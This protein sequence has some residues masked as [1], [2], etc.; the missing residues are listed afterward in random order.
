AQS[1]L[2]E[3]AIRPLLDSLQAQHGEQRTLAIALGQLAEAIRE[4]A[5]LHPG[6]TDAGAGATDKRKRRKLTPEEIE[7]NRELERLRFSGKPAP[8]D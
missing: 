8:G 3:V 6:A 5:L 2:L 4:G 7:F 1:P